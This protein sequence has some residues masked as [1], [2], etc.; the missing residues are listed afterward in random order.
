[1]DFKGY[2]TKFA[3]KRFRNLQK[4]MRNL[5]SFHNVECM[6]KNSGPCLQLAAALTLL[7]MVRSVYKCSLL[8]DSISMIFFLVLS[9]DC[10]NKFICM[11]LSLC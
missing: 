6:L 8:V 9:T 3:A 1:M 10:S 7:T 2:Y 5:I 11:K 4:N